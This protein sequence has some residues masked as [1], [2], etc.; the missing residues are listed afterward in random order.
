VCR[1]LKGV[2][3]QQ[4][5]RWTGS[6]TKGRCQDVKYILQRLQAGCECYAALSGL[7][8]RGA[9][10]ENKTDPQ[11]LEAMARIFETTRGYFD[12][13]TMLVP[14]GPSEHNARVLASSTLYAAVTEMFSDWQKLVDD[15]KVQVN[16]APPVSGSPVPTKPAPELLPARS[17]DDAEEEAV[18]L[19]IYSKRDGV[20]PTRGGTSMSLSDL[21]SAFVALNVALLTR[22]SPF[23]QQTLA[24]ATRKKQEIAATTVLVELCY[25]NAVLPSLAAVKLILLHA[26]AAPDP[27]AVIIRHML[28]TTNQATAAV[29]FDPP[30]PK[31]RSIKS[32][33]GISKQDTLQYRDELFCSA[34]RVIAFLKSP[35]GQSTLHD[36]L[37][38]HAK[39]LPSLAGKL[40]GGTAA[41]TELSSC[42]VWMPLFDS[43]PQVSSHKHKRRAH[44]LRRQPSHAR[45]WCFDCLQIKN[46]LCSLPRN[47]LVALLSSC[48]ELCRS[49]DMLDY[50]V[51]NTTSMY[52]LNLIKS[53]DVKKAASAMQVAV[54]AHLKSL[55]YGAEFDSNETKDEVMS[56]IWS[57]N[58]VAKALPTK[59][60]GFQVNR[61]L[62]SAAKAFSDTHKGSKLINLDD[63]EQVQWCREQVRAQHTAN[64]VIVCMI[65]IG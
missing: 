45:A 4:I 58:T 38:G 17:F 5:S 34:D 35:D 63:A 41:M 23:E 10:E 2:T 3:S 9:S 61:I 65:G 1:D 51:S 21:A 46:H 37:N 53:A 30:L 47:H 52:K 64:S 60:Q 43:W 13:L 18:R 26:A 56:A 20:L 33:F 15:Y 16:A 57:A 55:S 54:A 39:L 59:A 48:P 42:L 19:N 31:L 14:H 49:M 50:A 28:V 27:F 62:K 29:A 24:A 36:L 11:L 6:A 8:R 40:D 32:D 22:A 44:A 25:L 7:A 12:W